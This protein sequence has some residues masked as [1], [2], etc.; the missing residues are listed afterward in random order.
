[1]ADAKRAKTP[2]LR[3]S[4]V[5][6]LIAIAAGIGVGILYPEMAMNPW[7]KALGDGFVKLIRMIIA[8]VIFCTVVSGIAH[9]HD[10]QKVGRVGL[11]AL[12]YFEIV[13]TF[14]LCIGLAVGNLVPIGEQLG[15]AGADASAVAAY[16]VQ[17]AKMNAL[18][19]VLHVIPDTFIG[20]F[21]AGEI[22]RAH[23]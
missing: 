8:P 20:A 10:T 15:A 16:T 11:K 9:M 21:A 6:V 19:M 4:Y 14:A 18:D 13:S 7:V 3:R 17:A 23:V 1:M 5:Q 22:G 12:I 2:L